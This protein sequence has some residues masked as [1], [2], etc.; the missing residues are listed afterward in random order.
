[1][2]IDYSEPHQSYTSLGAGRQRSSK[3]GAGKTFFILFIVAVLVFSS[4]FG[5]GWYFSQKSAKRAYR[6]AM[7]QQSLETPPQPSNQQATPP[8][9][10][11][12]PLPTTVQSQGHGDGTPPP[13]SSTTTPA[14]NSPGQQLSFFDTLPKGQKNIVLGSGINKKPTPSTPPQ[15]AAQPPATPPSNQPAIPKT[16]PHT[17][18]KGVFPATSYLVQVA[19]YKNRKD[20]EDLKNKLAVRGYS[21]AISEVTLNGKDTW[22]RVRIGHHLDKEAASQ[23]A[24]QLLMGAKIIPDQE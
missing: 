20:A 1:M 19:A 6:A 17:T 10:G 21:A 13:P 11:P 8:T 7:E 24:N 18:A 14:N 16:N 4:G 23:V 9:G 2:R 15:P 12:I 3:G 5:V 22:F